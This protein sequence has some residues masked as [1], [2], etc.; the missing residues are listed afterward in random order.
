MKTNPA[1]II[2]STVAVIVG[3]GLSI[4]SSEN[5]WQALV[6]GSL[7]GIWVLLLNSEG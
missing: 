6:A 1:G 2:I 3:L 7:L 5:F 4:T